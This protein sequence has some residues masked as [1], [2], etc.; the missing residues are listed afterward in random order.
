MSANPG[1]IRAAFDSMQSRERLGMVIVVATLLVTFVW[2]G[3]SFTESSAPAPKGGDYN[4]QTVSYD[5]VEL[6]NTT[7]VSVP[8]VDIV[9][10]SAPQ[11]LSELLSTIEAGK[12]LSFRGTL[13]L[14][15]DGT[16]KGGVLAEF[17]IPGAQG[18]EVIGMGGVA[19]PEEVSPGLWSYRIDM[20][21]PVAGNYRVRL[22][23]NDLMKT[24]HETYP[25]AEGQV[26]VPRS[27]A[28][29]ADHPSP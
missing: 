2:W 12:P 1:W 8:S 22:T 11:P 18:K 16:I 26:H 27:R 4:L 14:P 9:Q 13:A 10:K 3:S 6:P 21:A 23:F 5:P 19:I 24:P 28:T 29:R 17:V 15:A 7:V 20:A 25:V